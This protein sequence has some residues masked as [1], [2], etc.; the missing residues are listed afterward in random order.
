MCKGLKQPKSLHLLSLSKRVKGGKLKEAVS[1]HNLTI[2]RNFSCPEDQGR[3]EIRATFTLM[4][5]ALI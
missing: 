5:A 4:I 3:I 1:S 2:L